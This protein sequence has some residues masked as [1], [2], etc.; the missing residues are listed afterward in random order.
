MMVLSIQDMSVSELKERIETVKAKL[1]KKRRLRSLGYVGDGEP[2]SWTIRNM[3]KYKKE[4]EAELK[5]RKA[6][7]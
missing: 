1:A 2:I 7:K 5:V 4:L 6:K 3:V